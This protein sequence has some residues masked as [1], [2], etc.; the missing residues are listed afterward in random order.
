MKEELMKG[1]NGMS[2]N[3]F[4]TTKTTA[5]DKAYEQLELE[6]KARSLEQAKLFITGGLWG[7]QSVSDE[8]K[9]ELCKWWVFVVPASKGDGVDHHFNGYNAHGQEG[10]V[11]SKIMEFDPE[12]MTGTTRSGRKYQLIGTPGYDG[13]AEYVRRGWLS[14]NKIAEDDVSDATGDYLTLEQKRFLQPDNPE[15]NDV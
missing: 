15:W 13:D 14:I 9:I 2:D 6:N 12:T 5:T 3:D 10:R 8:P 7:T 1:F 4:K 11:S